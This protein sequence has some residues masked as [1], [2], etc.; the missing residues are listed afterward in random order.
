[1]ALHWP[2]GGEEEALV[3]GSLFRKARKSDK[4]AKR[5]LQD[6]YGVRL[7]SEQERATLVY[8]TPQRKARRGKQKAS[9]A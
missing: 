1:M 8:S 3:R 7:F 4:K 2:L 6:T 5:E 9:T